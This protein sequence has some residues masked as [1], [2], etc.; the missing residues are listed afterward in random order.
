MPLM[1]K[2]KT[3]EQP[4][5]LHDAIIEYFTAKL[6]SGDSP[7]IAINGYQDFIPAKANNRQLLL[8]ISTAENMAM[9]NDGRIA[10]TFSCTLYAV[11]SKAQKDAGLQAMNLASAIAGR[12]H[13]NTWGYSTKAVEHP[14]KVE[15]NESF[16]I[17]GGDQHAGFEAWEITWQQTIK[18]GK[19]EVPVDASFPFMTGDHLVTGIFLN[20]NPE[21]SNI[22]D[23]EDIKA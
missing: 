16:L 20:F 8:E 7:D 21:D 19:E 10:Q 5:Q 22:E 14:Q 1:S 18:L 4:S 6:A 11:I 9:Q 3:I 23:Y 17:K 15:L 12:I 2:I 13:L